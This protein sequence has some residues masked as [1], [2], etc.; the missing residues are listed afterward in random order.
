[1]LVELGNDVNAVND[2]GET[3]LHGAAYRGANTIV[4]YLVEKGAKLDARS[5]QGWTPWTIANGVF[6][7]LFFKEQQ[8]D[9][10]LPREADGRARHLDRRHGRRR[11][12]LLRLRPQQPRLARRRRQ[13]RGAAAPDAVPRTEIDKPQAVERLTT[14]PRQ[15]GL[16]LRVVLC[17]ADYSPA[18]TRTSRPAARRR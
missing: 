16:N 1:M 10:R 7:T 2:R 15:E 13:P 17:D 4:Q 14:A 5:K 3:A 12:D 18:E 8:H 11:P 9:R 6:Y